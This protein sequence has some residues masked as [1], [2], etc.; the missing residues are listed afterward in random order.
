MFSMSLGRLNKFAT[1][2][3][4]PGMVLVIVL[5]SGAARQDSDEAVPPTAGTLVVANLRSESL[6]FHN[7]ANGRSSTLA[8]PGAP[9]E[10]EELNGRL[11]ITLGRTD[12]L[13]E[14]DPAVPAVLR[15]LR[16]AGEPHG[17]AVHG[18]ELVVSLDGRDALMAIDLEKWTP[19]WVSPTGDTPHV[20]ASDGTALFV[21]DTRANT[22][23]RLTAGSIATVQPAGDMPEALALAGAYVV[24]A[25]YGSGT[26]S[27]FDA[28]TLGQVTTVEVGAGPVRVIALDDTRVAVARQGSPEVVVVAIPTGEV[29]DRFEAPGRPDGLCLSPDEAHLAVASN[30]ENAAAVYTVDSWDR[31]VVVPMGDGP[32]ACTWLPR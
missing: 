6:T 14:V 11:Y 9:H 24:A 8:L 7:F 28:G 17:I 19:S 12:M 23:R 3:I 26:L 4:L 5:F 20:V 16:I 21:T 2:A 13:V 27:I 22:V 18:D 10:M 30:D 25:N 1:L 15:T 32:G 31:A 29:L